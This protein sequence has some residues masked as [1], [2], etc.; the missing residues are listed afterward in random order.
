M[1][2]KLIPRPLCPLK[3]REGKKYTHI[4]LL[5]ALWS[6]PEDESLNSEI[7]N[8]FADRLLPYDKLPNASG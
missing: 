3:R 7:L 6:K 8:K 4:E 5:R 1:F 2:K